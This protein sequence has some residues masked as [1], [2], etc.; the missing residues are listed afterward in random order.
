[1]G[2][3]FASPAKMVKELVYGPE[4]VGQAGAAVLAR[5]EAGQL[6]GGPMGGFPHFGMK[7]DPSLTFS[8]YVAS[9]QKFQGAA[10]LGA[11]KNVSI[12]QYPA[13]PSATAPEA[14][15]TWLQDWSSM[16]GIVPT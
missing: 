1:M 3:R 5:Y 8:G 12:Q 9:P 11:S 10:Q 15:P 7:G 2:R 4:P 14:L 16:E 6:S 13:L